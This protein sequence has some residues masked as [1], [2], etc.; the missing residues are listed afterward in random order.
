MKVIKNL[1][2]PVFIIRKTFTSC[3]KYI[4][5]LT[6]LKVNRRR[7]TTSELM[8]LTNI[9]F[10]VFLVFIVRL[11][12]DFWFDGGPRGLFLKDSDFITATRRQLRA[13]LGDISR[14]ITSL[15]CRKV[16]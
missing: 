11:R 8:F 6:F 4:I 10:V 13:L 1:R 2:R 14:V 9:V 16:T 12:S 15:I 7:S 3:I 5:T